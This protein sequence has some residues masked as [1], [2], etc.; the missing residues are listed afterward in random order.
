ME[1]KKWIPAF[2]RNRLTVILL[3]AAGILMLLAGSFFYP[4][5]TTEAVGFVS[6]SAV[7]EDRIESLCLAVEGMESVSVMVTLAD[8]D[9]VNT[10]EKSDFYSREYTYTLVRSDGRESTVTE[11]H[12]VVA[13]VAVVCTDGD[14]PQIQLK[15][16]ELLAAALGISASEISVCG[17]KLPT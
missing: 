1:E 6:Y 10:A 16:T 14:N 3:F 8:S 5:T 13:G 11:I 4:E 15:L 2:I 12:P 17:A 7:L 9:Y